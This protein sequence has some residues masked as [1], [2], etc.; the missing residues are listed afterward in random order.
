MD[1]WYHFHSITGDELDQ[2]FLRVSRLRDDYGPY[3]EKDVWV[4]AP[5]PPS[6]IRLTH[7]KRA[8][9]D[10]YRTPTGS[11]LA[12]SEMGGTDWEWSGKEPEEG[13]VWDQEGD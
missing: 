7:S 1:G 2:S 9:P 3:Q 4:G 10:R 12:D 6:K 8:T 5:G 11:E 13:K